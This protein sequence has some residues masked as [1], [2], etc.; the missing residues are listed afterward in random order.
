VNSTN[1]WAAT[2]RY[3]VPLRPHPPS[4]LAPYLLQHPVLL[5]ARV[6]QYH[7]SVIGEEKEEPPLSTGSQEHFF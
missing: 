4:H 3:S 1:I 2:T 6:S 5:L 7:H